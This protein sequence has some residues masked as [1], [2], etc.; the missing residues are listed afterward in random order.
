MDLK[1]LRFEVQGWPATDVCSDD[2]A[3]FGRECVSRTSASCPGRGELK[4][5][6]TDEIVNL[7]QAFALVD[8]DRRARDRDHR[9]R[10][11]SGFF[12]AQ[13]C[14]G[15]RG[16]WWAALRRSHKPCDAEHPPT[17]SL[18]ARSMGLSLSHVEN[19]NDGTFSVPL[20]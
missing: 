19:G 11:R 15:G 14:R 20:D 3:W 6:S 5:V 13:I 17:P 8:Q 18:P 7:D 10:L 9:H 4:V 1:I 16:D 2:A 12:H